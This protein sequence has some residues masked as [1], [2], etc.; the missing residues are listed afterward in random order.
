MTGSFWAGLPDA[1]GV[2]L[3]LDGRG[4]VLYVGRSVSLRARVRSYWSSPDPYR[5]HLRPMLR[6]VRRVDHVECETEH[7]AALL[8]RELIARHEPPFNLTYGVEAEWWLRFEAGSGSFEAVREPA[9]D[10][11]RYFGPYLGGRRV[12]LALAALRRLQGHDL[13][14]ILVGDPAAVEACLAELERKRDIAAEATLFEKASELQETIRAVEWL[15]QASSAA[16]S[17]RGSDPADQPPAP[18]STIA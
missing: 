16:P 8:E 12:R 15:A 2:Y 6:R 7:N 4:R 3:M 10:A 9:E 5:A 17:D 1:P 14:A 11:A 18:S 13:P